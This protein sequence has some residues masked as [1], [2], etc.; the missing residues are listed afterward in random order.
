M[1]KPLVKN[2]TRSDRFGG[3]YIGHRVQI[4]GKQISVRWAAPYGCI[5]TRRKP[6]NG[7]IS[8]SRPAGRP[9]NWVYVHRNPRKVVRLRQYSCSVCAITPSFELCIFLFFF[10]KTLVP[11]AVAV[12]YLHVCLKSLFAPRSDKVASGCD[13]IE[14][15]QCRVYLLNLHAYITYS[16]GKKPRGKKTDSCNKLEGEKSCGSCGRAGKREHAS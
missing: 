10:S 8:E 7:K 9:S 1:K 14:R 13:A 6:A 12:Y 2:T 4:W 15:L 3:E 16:H 5:G 11:P